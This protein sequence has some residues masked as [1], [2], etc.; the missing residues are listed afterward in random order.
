M[1]AVLDARF[2]GLRVSA[3]LVAS[4]NLPPI[5][6]PQGRFPLGVETSQVGTR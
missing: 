6:P 3:R 4:V 1:G 2:V 5:P